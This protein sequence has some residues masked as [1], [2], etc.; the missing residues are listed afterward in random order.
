M[1]QT[2]THEVVLY[3]LGLM[4]FAWIVR[5][6]H[7]QSYG[8]YMD[9]LTR[10]PRVFEISTSELGR[11]VANSFYLGGLLSRPLHASFIYTFSFLGAQFGRIEALYVIAFSIY[12][13]NIVLFFLF[14]RRVANNPM[15]VIASILFIVFPA[16]T[17]QIFLTQAFGI[18]PSITF[19]LLGFH[20]Y[21]SNR[22]PWAYTL[23]FLS[24][25]TYEAAFAIFLVAPLLSRPADKP[26]RSIWLRHLLILS[27]LMVFGFLLRYIEGD[28]ELR[29]LGSLSTLWT[30]VRHII[31]GP[32]VSLGSFIFRPI[33]TFFIMRT[34][35]FYGLREVSPLFARVFSISRLDG[36][37]EYLGMLH[38]DIRW[39]VGA[40]IVFLVPI[41]MKVSYQSR[42]TRAVGQAYEGESYGLVDKP[43]ARISINRLFISATL[44]LIL[45][46]P[47]IL[48]IPEYTIRGRN[49]RVHYAAV[50]GASLLLALVIY[51]I[52]R[53]MAGKTG[54]IARA[55]LIAALLAFLIGSAFI[56]QLDYRNAWDY[57]Q[58][59]WKALLPVIEDVENGEVV[60]VDPQGLI[61][62]WQI[63]ANTWNLPRVLPQLFSFP[64]GVE[65]PPRVYR[66]LEGWE[67]EM[68]EF[69]VLDERTTQA[70]PSLFTT[71]DPKNAA[72]IEMSSGLPVRLSELI[73]EDG[74]VVTFKV[75]S[76]DHHMSYPTTKLFEFL[77]KDD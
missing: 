1:K 70:P 18:Q 30:L 49:T 77:I 51:S 22:L 16:D 29:G 23:V 68:G 44:M 37:V 65:D 10:I 60:M 3:V 41:L 43:L 75:P 45:A 55:G 50:L 31:L 74:S 76:S 71:V 35:I 72:F 9:D 4:V 66:L 56:V 58:T 69:I 15:A 36:S 47:L 73:L 17:T 57:Q 64:A 52:W 59:F 2:Q 5:Y 62:S 21:L 7:F 25:L 6:W 34:D 48:V 13:L 42:K 39:I 46:Y 53:R 63:E 8:F 14:V 33:E 12:A 61:D 26:A 54:W 27:G 40:A 38:T 20:A 19:L 11:L 28:Q 67:L 32:L 24:L